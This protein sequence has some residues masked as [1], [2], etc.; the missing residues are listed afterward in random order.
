MSSLT[1][2][3]P[4]KPQAPLPQA[5]PAPLPDHQMVEHIYAE[6]LA[7]VHDLPRDGD[8]FGGGSRVARGV[9]VGN[10]DR[11]GVLFERFFEDEALR[12]SCNVGRKSDSHEESSK[13]LREVL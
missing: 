3:A 13:G 9:V 6:E 4:A 10:D 5:Y 2:P 8:V 1:S 11:G 12:E 7:G